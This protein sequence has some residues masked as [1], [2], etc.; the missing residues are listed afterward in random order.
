MES[1]SEEKSALRMRVQD[2][3]SP[4]LTLFKNTGKKTGPVVF[5]LAPEV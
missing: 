3:H 1:V 2:D 5:C 4:T